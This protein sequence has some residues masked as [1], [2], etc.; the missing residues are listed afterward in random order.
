M[1]NLEYDYVIIGSG[2]GGSVSALRL[3]EKGYKVLVIEKGKRLGAEDFPKTNWN[4]RKWMWMP[5]LGMQGLF[6]L[7]F[8]RHVAVLSG[9]GVG[10]GS[11]VYA[12]TLPVPK[13]EFFNS[14]HWNGLENWEEEL[15][16]FYALAKKML[17]AT[18]HPYTSISEKVMK[19]LAER[20]G[21]PEAFDK[22]EVAVY[23]G[24]QDV[25]VPDP[26]FDGK[27]PT[28]TG[29]NQCGGCML[30]CRYNAKNTLD[31]NYLY[32]AEQL[33]VKVI[34]EK[35]VFDVIPLSI[36]GADGYEIHFKDSLSYFPKKDSVKTKSVIFSGGVLGTVDLLLKL[37]E[38]SLPNLSDKVGTGIRTNSESLI[39][40]TS[41]DKDAV[42]S[43][44]IAIGSIINIDESRHI[45]PVKYSDGSGF[46]RIFMAPMVQGGNI[47][48][49]FYRMVKDLFVHPITN[50]KAAFI[51]DWSKRSQIL[52]YMESIDSTLSFKR[53]I[54]GG[55]KSNLDTGPAP[56]AF[57][58]KAQELANHVA[59]IINGKAMTLS[60][61]TLFGIPT[62]AHILGGACMG[63][64]AQEGVID[65][66][67]FVFN[68]K[69]M[70]VCDGAM[71]S[72]NPGVNPSLSITAISERAMSKIPNKE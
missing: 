62:T 46:W 35:E 27:G 42:F 22:T 53:N 49:R 68:Y 41:F 13:S 1:A 38:K 47:F 63:N 66:D 24:K 9:V 16:P 17:G 61:E 34:A 69:N 4:L 65:K 33:G 52:L 32:L 40:V 45:E 72:A 2:F 39:G 30:G 51:D 44:G 55:L 36:D 11:L 25:T 48:T 54:L 18:K 26:Y 31:K 67:N 58:P 6:K 60:T 29:C 12:N 23:F 15:K 37:K 5:K 7:T 57:N 21:K 70:M 19:E 28:R 10:G 50:L 43:K 59:E 14:G 8:F 64:N 20:I 3:A 56:T 71:I